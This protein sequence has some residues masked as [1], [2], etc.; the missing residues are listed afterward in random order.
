[1]TGFPLPVYGRVRV[2][3][4]AVSTQAGGYRAPVHGMGPRTAAQRRLWQVMTRFGTGKDL[5]R[6]SEVAIFAPLHL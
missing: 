2:G 3:I 1:M 6:R 4:V 5:P